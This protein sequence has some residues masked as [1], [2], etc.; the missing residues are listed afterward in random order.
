MTDW[1]AGNCLLNGRP[2]ILSN[3]GTGSEQQ[4]VRWTIQ[5]LLSLEV[6]SFLQSSHW[7][8]QQGCIVGLGHLVCPSPP[9]FPRCVRYCQRVGLGQTHRRRSQ[10]CSCLHRLLSQSQDDSARIR[11]W[12]QTWCDSF[13]PMCLQTDFLWLKSRWCE[14]CRMLVQRVSLLK[15]VLACRC[16]T[17]LRVLQL[18]IFCL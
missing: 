10:G 8:N 13:F 2:T 16:L 4:I 1:S 17:F 7:G 18:L 5:L 9:L 6:K 3:P 14:N 12:S 11:A 15:S